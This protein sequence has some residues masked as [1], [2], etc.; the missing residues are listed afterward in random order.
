MYLICP[1][2]PSAWGTLQCIRGGRAGGRRRLQ[3]PA[4]RSSGSASFSRLPSARGRPAGPATAGQ[5]QSIHVLGKGRERDLMGTV[6]GKGMWRDTAWHELGGCWALERGLAATSGHPS[7]QRA[8]TV[9]DWNPTVEA[10]N[11]DVPD[12]LPCALTFLTH[13]IHQ[14]AEEVCRGRERGNL[15]SY[16]QPGLALPGLTVT[17][18]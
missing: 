18:G 15:A 13:Q 5:S 6:S 9:D 12:I 16:C 17:T 4:G 8:W 1:P 2:S 3:G 14:G 7:R 10:Q 11:L